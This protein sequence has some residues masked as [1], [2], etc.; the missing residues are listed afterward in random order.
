MRAL[1]QSRAVV[2][3]TCAA[4]CGV[5]ALAA[6]KTVG[7]PRTTLALLAV[8]ALLGELLFVSDEGAVAGEAGESGQ[9]FSFSSGVHL[10]AVMLVGPWGAALVA[11]LGVSVVDSL[12]GAEARKAA[13]NAACFGLAAAAGGVAFLLAGGTPGRIYV[14]DDAG[15]ICALA[16]TYWTVNALLVGLVVAASSGLP[17]APILRNRLQPELSG[18]AELGFAVALATLA[19]TQAWAVLALLP[20]LIAVHRAHDRLATLRRETARALETFANVV[21]ER[22]PYT[23]VHSRRVSEYAA[24]LAVAVGLRPAEVERIRRAGRLHDLGK[25]AVDE[26]ILR[27]PEKLDEA[28]WK[29]LRRHARLSARLL[30]RFRFAA[31]E[32]RAVEYHHERYDGHGYYGLSGD[33]IP[34]A[35]HFLIVADAFDAMTTDRSYRRALTREE[36]LAAIERE[37]GTQF[38]PELGACF[39][40]VQRG[41]D[42]AAAIGEDGLIA[43]RGG[44]HR[45]GRTRFTRA[46]RSLEAAVVVGLVGGL[47]G[48]AVGSPLATVAG[49]GLALGAALALL[50]S[51][52]RANRLGE[53]IRAAVSGSDPSWAFERTVETLAG[54][55]DVRWAGLLAWE[56]RELDGQL[57]FERGVSTGPSPSA[58]TSWLLREAESGLDLLRAARGE[59]GRSDIH[60]AL[61]LHH[62]ARVSG[63]LVFAFGGEPPRHVVSALR[64]SSPHLEAVLAPVGISSPP[65]LALLP[66]RTVA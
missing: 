5:L 1:L 46:L 40:A 15:A 44:V 16:L 18:V 30:G 10:A 42:P 32:A 19:L 28:E 49:G 65:A 62:D 34:L 57:I 11:A 29:V 63:F 23:F 41:N 56:E 6:L 48:I 66:V 60:L 8:G 9:S 13:F 7:L 31:A 22:D 35:A 53:R 21:D 52:I 2:A 61:A 24:E 45:A 39:V 55:I 12:R 37:L 58:L 27:K 47:L 59:L 20:L 43:L 14:G 51:S 3:V 64:A 17:L 33:E 36:A 25:V 54:E 4:G 38:H 50:R 26:A